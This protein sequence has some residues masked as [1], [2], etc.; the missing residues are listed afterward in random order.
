MT[1]GTT[2]AAMSRA[3]GMSHQDVLDG[4][5]TEPPGTYRWQ[6]APVEG[7]ADVPVDRYLSRRAHGQEKQHLWSRVW[8]VACREEHLRQ[9]GDTVVCDIAEKSYLPV[10]GREGEGGISA[11]PNACLHRGGALRDESGRISELQCV[12]HGFCWSLD[13][14]LKRI[15]GALAG[16]VRRCGTTPRA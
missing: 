12:F 7:L 5:R 15:P 2:K 14:K 8:Q 16:T 4:D 1:A 6:S 3:P 13:G 11:F 9:V 10:R